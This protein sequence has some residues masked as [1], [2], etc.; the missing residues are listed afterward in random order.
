[1]VCPR[2]RRGT[3]EPMQVRNMWYISLLLID[4]GRTLG[5]AFKMILESSPFHPIVYLKETVRDLRSDNFK[6]HLCKILSILRC[7]TAFLVLPPE[8]NDR[9]R[10]LKVWM[11][12]Q[13]AT[14][15]PI[16]AVVENPEADGVTIISRSG[17]Q[18]VIMEP[19]AAAT[20]LSYV[21]HAA[22]YLGQDREPSSLLSEGIFDTEP[23]GKAPAFLKEVSKIPIAGDS[24]SNIFI[25][26]GVGTGKRFFAKRIHFRSRK[27]KPFAVICCGSLPRWMGEGDF[28]NVEFP[29][30]E[31]LANRVQDGTLYID[32][33][34]CLPDSAQ[35]KLLHFLENK[36]YFSFG[37]E[38]PRPADFRIIAGSTI[39]A[40][41][42]LNSGQLRKDLYYRLNIISF[43]L[44]LLKDR[45]EDIPLLAEH[46]LKKYSA[47]AS[48]GTSFSPDAMWKLISYEWPGNIKE[49]EYTVWRTISLLDRK[50][51][52][53]SDIRIPVAAVS[54]TA[55]QLRRL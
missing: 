36:E 26:G 28:L 7:D 29:G 8:F 50:I 54:Q 32:E 9:I 10:E 49:L 47:P 5:P 30:A 35:I 55:Q 16:L 31:F 22:S 41:E 46:F 20:I 3:P 13:S 39:D 19:F 23:V 38:Q 18:A 17:G 48:R 1:L 15:L 6:D 25:S 27:S 11:Q 2:I 21:W 12:H 34:D 53:D 14:K 43:K 51:I 37:T 44:P 24:S 52:K 40:D 45:R 42:M 4:A 33:I